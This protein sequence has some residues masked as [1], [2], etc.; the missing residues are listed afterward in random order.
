MKTKSAV[1]TARQ[2]A[3][4]KQIKPDPN[5]P[6]KEFKNLAE[7]AASFDGQAEGILETLKVT[8]NPDGT[9]TLVDGERRWRAAELAGIER[10]PIEIVAPADVLKTQL[11]YGTQRENLNA[12]EQ[13]ATAQRLL[14]HRRAANPKFSVEEL[15]QELGHKRA[16]MYELLGLLKLHPPVLEALRAGVITPSHATRIA[17]VP[18]VDGQ[19]DL[20]KHIKSELE[21]NQTVSVAD[22]EEIIAADHC[23]SL[24][25]APFKLDQVFEGSYDAGKGQQML[26]KAMGTCAQ[27][28]HRSGNL[29]NWPDQKNPNMCLLPAC[30]RAKALA[31]AKQRGEAT[32]A[33]DHYEKNGKEYVRGEESRNWGNGWQSAKQA[34]GKHAPKPLTTVD[35][36]GEVIQVY[37]VSAAKEAMAKNGVKRAAPVNRVDPK[38]RAKEEADR[39]A[40]AAQQERRAKLAHDL[41]PRVRKGLAKLTEADAWRFLFQFHP[42]V[43]WSVAGTLRLLKLPALAKCSAAQLRLLAIE[44]TLG[45]D[46]EDWLVEHDGS[47]CPMGVRVCKLAGIDVKKEDKTETPKPETKPAKAAKK[48]KKK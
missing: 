36:T 29:P 34:M 20:V 41:L 26:L 17:V 1:Q 5:Q 47:F 11:I 16:T 3:L 24:K 14:T 30:Y 40:A 21:Y 7:L 38:A 12:L 43:E 31:A 8:A 45:D 46:A 48:G 18:D 23:K 10:L 44:L 6:R 13:A 33:P 4:R 22:L 15:G 42:E 27:C 28:P 35:R 32:L 37:P 19:M 39:K 25:G 9:Y 2:Y